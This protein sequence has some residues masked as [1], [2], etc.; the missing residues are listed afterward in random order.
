MAFNP[1]GFVINPL[2]VIPDEPAGN[3]RSGIQTDRGV[4]Q[5]VLLQYPCRGYPHSRSGFRRS[6]E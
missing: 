1:D 4:T 6:P 5:A 2:I 3:G